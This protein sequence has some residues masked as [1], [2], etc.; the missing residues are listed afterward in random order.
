MEE[1]RNKVSEDRKSRLALYQ[2]SQSNIYSS[3]N[4]DEESLLGESEEPEEISI[5]A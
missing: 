4:E 2:F 5:S 1:E 3:T